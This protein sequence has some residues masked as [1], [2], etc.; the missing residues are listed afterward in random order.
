MVDDPVSEYRALFE[1]DGE[2]VVPTPL[3]RGP[4]HPNALHGGAP[5]ALFA[6][7]CERHD[8]GPA[9]FMARLTV[10]LMRPVPL[11]PL[12]LTVRTIRPGRKVQWLEA[13]L[14]DEGGTEVARATALRVHRGEFNVQ[15]SVSPEVAPPPP[16]DAATEHA[17]PLAAARVG[18]WHAHDVRLVCGNWMEPGPGTSWFNLRCEVVRGDPVTPFQRV[19]ACADFGSGVGNPL[20]MTESAAINPEVSIH[21]MREPVGEWVALESGAWASTTGVGM[22]ESRLWDRDGVIGRGVQTLLVER[23]ADRVMKTNES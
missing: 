18:Y 9:S 13:A 21:V 23:A 7:A 6:W 5:S 2:R 11:A 3:A 15:G 10:E 22:A 1:R 16:P 17:F 12:G 14:H 19:A 8:P 20:R 4:W